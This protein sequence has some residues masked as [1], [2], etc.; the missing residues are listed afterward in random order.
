MSFAPVPQMIRDAINDSL[1][2]LHENIK[3]YEIWP[4]IFPWCPGCAAQQYSVAFLDDLAQPIAATRG[5]FFCT[6]HGL[7]LFTRDDR[8][9][10]LASGDVLDITE[11]INA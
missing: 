5:G 11:K 8:Y 7:I 3:D 2:R 1:L 6:T 10:T 9:Y 4:S